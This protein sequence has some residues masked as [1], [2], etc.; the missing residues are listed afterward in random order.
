MAQEKESRPRHYKKVANAQWDLCDTNEHVM[1]AAAL[2]IKD[3]LKVIAENLNNINRKYMNY[4]ERQK[5]E[6]R[7]QRLANQVKKLKGLK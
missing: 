1:I 6:R 5:Y 3:T 4:E 2:E 7:I